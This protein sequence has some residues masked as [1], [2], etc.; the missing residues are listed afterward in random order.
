MIDL[1]LVF[2]AGLLGSAHCLGM[3]GGF[4]L[5]VGS[6]AAGLRAGLARQTAYTAGRVCTYGFL[7]AV[8]GGLGRAAAAELSSWIDTM[9]WLGIAAGL[10]L[11]MEACRA[12]GWLPGRV[13]RGASAMACLAGGPFRGLLRGGG[14]AGVFVAG[15]GTGLLPCGLVYG[16]LA[17]AASRGT[18]GGGLATMLVFGAGTAPLMVAT[19]L[20]GSLVSLALRQ[21][22]LRF[23]AG[24]LLLS[25]MLAAGR[26]IYALAH[27]ASER[28]C[29][30]CAAAS[31]EN[32]LET[33]PAAPRAALCPASGSRTDSAAMATSTPTTLQ[34]TISSPTP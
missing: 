34:I 2:M 16:L 29:P 15:L 14:W 21:R 11:A 7:G 5:A 17:L 32:P 24:C 33:P 19:G 4:A 26:G 20:G 27:S 9:A 30:L 31:T 18:V 25:G 12:A 13:A 3:C 1:P 23:A 28:S 8:A 22:L 10:V 6:G